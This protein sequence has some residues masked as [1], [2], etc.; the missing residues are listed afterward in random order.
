MFKNIA[1]IIVYIGI[2][3]LSVVI[4]ARIELIPIQ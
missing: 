2:T 1:M 4:N 3:F